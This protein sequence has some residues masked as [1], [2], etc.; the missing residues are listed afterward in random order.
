MLEIS[1]RHQ[2]DF[3][4][5]LLRIDNLDAIRASR[6]ERDGNWVLVAVAEVLR[7]T[8]RDSDV[9]A[10]LRDD[11][12]VVLAVETSEDEAPFVE[13]RIAAGLAAAPALQPREEAVA[14]RIGVAPYTRGASLTELIERASRRL[15]LSEAP[16][17]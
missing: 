16:A 11:E 10:R 8:F 14:V 1:A 13:E 4:I 17:P 15:C 5:V 6:G 7:S 12:F 3:T 9:I 2:H